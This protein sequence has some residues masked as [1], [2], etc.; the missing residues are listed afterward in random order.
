[1]TAGGGDRA[2]TL[3][4]RLYSL[5]G[6]TDVDTLIQHPY[7]VDNTLQVH[8]EYLS[9]T[10]GVDVEPER[11]PLAA[12]PGHSSRTERRLRNR[13]AAIGQTYDTET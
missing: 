4:G 1:M 6:N 11:L 9:E 12:T 13:S 8:S 5:D 7:D 2:V 10:V 3:D